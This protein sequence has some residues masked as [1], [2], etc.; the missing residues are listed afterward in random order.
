MPADMTASTDFAADAADA[1]ARTLRRAGLVHAV[2]PLLWIGQAALLSRVVADDIAAGSGSASTALLPAL[3]IAALGIGRTLLEACAGRLAFRAA[4]SELSRLR[5]EAARTLAH[6]SPLDIARAPSGRAASTLAE[7]AEAV[8]PYLARFGPA[9]LRAALVPLVLF[10]VV[11]W[12]SWAAALVLALTAP[13]IPFFMALIG[14]RAQA[15]SEEQLVAL[16]G[17]NAFLL[18]RLRGLATLRAHKAV[19]DTARRLRTDA[20]NLRRRTMKVLRIA[21]L[22]SAVLE[23]FA[24]A[25]VA[26]VAAYVGLHLLGALTFGSW[27]VPLGL[28]HGLFVLLLAPAF[29]EP[30]RELAAIWH[31]RAAGRAGL[32]ALRALARDGATLVGGDTP[33]AEA[34][35]RRLGPPAIAFE[36][37]AFRHPGAPAALFEDFSLDVAPGEHVA[38]FAPSGA[39]KST[40]LALIAGLAAPD[41]GTVRIGGEALDAASAGRLRARMAHVGQSPHIFAGT[42]KG[43]A[44]LGR[45][46]I[47]GAALAGAFATARLEHVAMVRGPAP[48]G[49]AGRGMSGGEALRLALARLALAEGADLLL[50]DEPTAHLDALTAHEVSDALMSLARGRTLIVATHDPA[51]AARM[52]RIVRLDG[53]GAA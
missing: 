19:D 16:G 27:G 43:N 45:P 4:R 47:G 42:L 44:S 1:S 7:Q 32:E 20:E 12:F 2:A 41:A 9:R 39:G 8:L 36:G 34:D 53:E 50:A 23:L 38:L 26:M 48:V 17:M 21:F 37:V 22:S 28:E 24:A 18:D 29:Y 13:F 14:L 33:P 6:G 25:G 40:L 30:L 3:A 52:D 5:Y 51:L 11:L 46:G 15:A 10:A 31:D 49:E 35:I